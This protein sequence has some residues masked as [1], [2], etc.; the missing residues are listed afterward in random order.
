MRSGMYLQS[1]VEREYTV[2]GGPLS[3]AVWLLQS[4]VAR[5]CGVMVRIVAVSVSAAPPVAT[6]TSLAKH[7]L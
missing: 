6:A 3:L 2:E 7:F 5:K 1:G 4:G